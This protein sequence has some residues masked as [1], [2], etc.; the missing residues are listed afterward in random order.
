M[1]SF[2]ASAI[3]PRRAAILSSGSVGYSSNVEEI[4][5]LPIVKGYD[6]LKVQEFYE[7]VSRNHDAL[8]TMGEA[9]ILRGFVMSTLNK[10]RQ[11]SGL[12]PRPSG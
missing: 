1:F 11:K 6:Y 2:P 7:T 4:V 9:D 3:L 10:L 12:N 8:L 5:K